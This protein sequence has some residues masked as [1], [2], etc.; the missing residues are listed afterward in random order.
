MSD[1]QISESDG[2]RDDASQP[3]VSVI[4]TTYNIQDYIDRCLETLFTQTYTN[5]ELII[6]DDASKDATLD[7][8]DRLVAGRDDCRVIALAENTPGGVGTP[9][10]IGIEAATGTYI[11]FADGD[12]WYEPDMLESM[13]ELGEREE[14]DFVMAKYKVYSEANNKTSEPADQH[15]WGPLMGQ[16][17]SGLEVDELRQHVLKF[18]AVPWRKLYRRDFLMTHNL[19]FPEGDFFFEDNPFHWFCTLSASRMAFLP[20]SICFHRVDRP[21]QTMGS[22]GA[23]LLYFYRHHETI[24]TWLKEHDLFETYQSDLLDWMIAQFSWTSRRIR[25]DFAVAL[26]EEI[27]GVLAGYDDEIVEQQLLELMSNLRIFLLLSAAR[28]GDRDAF[29]D[30]ILREN[31]AKEYLADLGR[32]RTETRKLRDD[33][34]RLELLHKGSMRM[35]IGPEPEGRL[36]MKVLSAAR[37]AKR[38]IGRKLAQLSS[39]L[40]KG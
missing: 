37:G 18:I 9:A 34:R 2:Q 26:F 40:P 4:V 13:V 21:G 19:R 25:P 28:R 14:A 8:I 29:L 38:S 24:A 35:L 12:D 7:Q 20:K 3:K 23:E 22:N 16:I 1:G 30:I 17:A 6:I 5:F 10:N 15:R 32:L 36:P 27:A 39:L 33:I 31:Q 11:A